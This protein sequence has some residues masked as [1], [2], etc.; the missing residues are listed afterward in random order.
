MKHAKE[1]LKVV[2]RFETSALW[3]VTR[4][5]ILTHVEQPSLF[6]SV[7]Q[8]GDH[9]FLGFADGEARSECRRH[10]RDCCLLTVCSILHRTFG[11]DRR[12][13]GD[14]AP[15]IRRDGAGS[16]G[17]TALLRDGPSSPSPAT[18]DSSSHRSGMSHLRA[19]RSLLLDLGTSDALVG[20]SQT[21]RLSAMASRRGRPQCCQADP[22]LGEQAP[23]LGK[24]ASGCSVRARRVRRSYMRKCCQ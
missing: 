19:R 4:E 6:F 14:R 7:S 24:V 2:F 17:H 23:R 12:G 1:G 3:L 8:S 22:W 21:R 11:A 9:P 5:E 15:Q 18:G 13:D 20:D 16:N 10:S